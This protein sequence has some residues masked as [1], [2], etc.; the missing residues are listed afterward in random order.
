[1]ATM[2]TTDVVA[3]VINGVC[4]GRITRFEEFIYEENE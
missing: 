2:S 1:M 4:S 3:E